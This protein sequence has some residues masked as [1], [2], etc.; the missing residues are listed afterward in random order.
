MSTDALLENDIINCYWGKKR[1]MGKSYEGPHNDISHD[2]MIYE[3]ALKS[4]EIQ[5]F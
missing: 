2:V 5:D 1:K 4:Q 3:N